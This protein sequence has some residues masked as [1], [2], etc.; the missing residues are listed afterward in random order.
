MN[1]AIIGAG[2]AGLSCAITLEKYGYQADIFE[3]R[4]MVG[5]RFIFAEIMSP[6]MHPP[7]SDSVQFLS[8]EYGIDLKPTSNISKI[9]V[10]SANESAVIEGKLGFINMRGKH[11]ESYEQQLASQVKAPIH[12]NQTVKYEKI[13]KEYTHVIL[14]T[15]DTK[16]VE[17]IQ[18]FK[19]AMLVE[20]KGA[21]VKGEFERN[22]VHTWFDHTFAPKGMVYFL[23]HSST[24][25]SLVLVYPQYPE[26]EGKN[27]GDLWQKAYEKAQSTLN[28][29]LPITDEFSLSDY[30]V[31]KA[32]N[33]RI[34]N[35]FFTGNC[36]GSISPFLGFG[37]FTSILSGIYAALDICGEGDYVEL[38]KPIMQKYH[39]SLTLRRSFEKLSNNQIDLVTKALKVEAVEKALTS[40]NF[41]LL[42][43]LSKVIHPFSRN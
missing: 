24:E 37:E 42:K 13:A 4:G 12:F 28:Q 30:M 6:I 18:S 43:L 7:V 39:D 22:H 29:D 19:A 34:G 14:A 15:G 1:I 27:K 26:N 3:R 38:T 40:P 36:L 41:S 25:A 21:I 5:D 35:T 31:G 10:H 16:D 32:M 20:F 17:Q 8:K 33:P 11:P 2:M 9:H 23:P